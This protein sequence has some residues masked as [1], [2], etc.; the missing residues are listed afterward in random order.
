MNTWLLFFV[1]CQQNTSCYPVIIY[2]S[3]WYTMWSVYLVS[4]WL[5]CK[6]IKDR[7]CKWNLSSS[8][9]AHKINFDCCILNVILPNVTSP[10]LHK[11]VCLWFQLEV[12][13]QS[14]SSSNPHLMHFSSHYG[15]FQAQRLGTFLMNLEKFI[16][17]A[18]R[19]GQVLK[20]LPV[21][22][23]LLHSNMIALRVRLG[24]D[25]ASLRH[26]WDNH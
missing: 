13:F 22:S 12:H 21:L 5:R 17:P 3:I 2:C 11:K 9:P 19:A 18:Q 25:K 10:C 4:R 8:I 20:H 23:S 7:N 6:I 26:S 14:I 1:P 15:L 24:K 16:K